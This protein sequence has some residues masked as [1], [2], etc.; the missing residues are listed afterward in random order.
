MMKKNISTFFI[1]FYFSNNGQT[2]SLLHKR[3][4][5]GK[6]KFINWPIPSLEQSDINYINTKP[7]SFSP[8]L[9]RV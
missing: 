5:Q 9:Y 8:N 6:R 4:F 3:C 1:F 7:N 2:L